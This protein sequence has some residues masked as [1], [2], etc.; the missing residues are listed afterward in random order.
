MKKVLALLL[1]CLLATSVAFAA[2][3]FSGSLTA[4]MAGVSTHMAM[5]AMTLTR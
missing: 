2:V 3:Q 4:A 1:V 5:M